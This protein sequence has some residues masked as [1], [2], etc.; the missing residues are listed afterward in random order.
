MSKPR[1]RWWGYVRA[2][3]RAY[4]EL[5]KQVRE[6]RQA[7]ITAC[8]SH[9]GGS[10]GLSNPTA[11]AALR[12]LPP[13]EQRE[14]EAVEAAVRETARMSDGET[15]LTIIELVFWRQSHTL[16]GAAQAVHL[17]YRA[18]KERQQVFIRLVAQNLGFLERGANKA[19]KPC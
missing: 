2:V 5:R 10:G 11:A 6:L 16:A 3:I 17:G 4:P 9:S 13:Q 12:Q 7:S 18:A 14:Y 1:D 19:K 8:R 15:R